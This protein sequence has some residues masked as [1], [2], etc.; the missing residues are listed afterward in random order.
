MNSFLVGICLPAACYSLEG[1]SSMEP[2]AVSISVDLPSHHS[3][4]PVHTMCLLCIEH[5]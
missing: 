1:T 4:L 2:A 5:L 3:L